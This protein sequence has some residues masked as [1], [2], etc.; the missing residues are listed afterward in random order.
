MN[1][2]GR[3]G[4]ILTCLV[5]LLTA[6]LA[7]GPA[8]AQ[9]T[10]G[11]P[12]PPPG[13]TGGEKLDKSYDA[14]DIARIRKLLGVGRSGQEKT[15]EY[16][17]SVARG[18]KPAADWAQITVTYDTTPKWIDE[19]VIQY[20]VLTM[21]VEEGKTVYS[22]F[23]ATVKYVDVEKGR[24]HQGSVYLRPSVLKRHGNVVAAAVE[25]SHE[26]K[27]IQTRSEVDSESG[28][29][30]EKWWADDSKVMKSPMVTPR[31]GY[32]LDRSQTPFALINI[33]DYE[34]SK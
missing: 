9:G 10:K 21:I 1:N 22:F 3:N 11:R 7:A 29:K 19:L 32:L 33:D 24:D 27:V 34:V 16:K 31:D 13:R 30:E 6:A 25:I 5:A 28:V 14:T 26:G 23:K 12:L 8:R 2:H 15:P 4:I 17:T 20:Y 18:I